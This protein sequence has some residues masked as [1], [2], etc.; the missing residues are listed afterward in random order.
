MSII[1]T[2]NWYF[3]TADQEV[4]LSF[5]IRNTN[6]PPPTSAGAMLHGATA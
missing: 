1:F 4:I 3:L 6:I 2:I 5:T